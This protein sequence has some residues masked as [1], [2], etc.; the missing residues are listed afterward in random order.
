M[1]LGMMRVPPRKG[2]PNGCVACPVCGERIP[3][4]NGGPERLR[5]ILM[6]NGDRL[7]VVCPKRVARK[8]NF[9]L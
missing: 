6:V 2:E 3:L 5:H 9:W 1:R 8:F 4:I 7:A